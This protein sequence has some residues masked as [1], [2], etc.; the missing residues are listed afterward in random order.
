MIS[1]ALSPTERSTPGRTKHRTV[2]ERHALYDVLDT[3]LVCHIGLVLDDSPVVLP[4]GYGRDDDTLYLHGSTGARSLRTPPDG[5]D[6]CVTVTHVDGIVYARSLNHHSM[7][8]RSAVV[9]GRARPVTERDEKLHGL[10]V[11]TEHLA[12]GSWD[13][14]RGVSNKEYA[15]VSVLALP[16]HEASVKVRAEGPNDDPEDVEANAVWAGVLPVRQM[17]GTPEP[18]ADLATDL[19]VPTHV[20]A[21]AAA[22]VAGHAA[23]DTAD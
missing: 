10:K 14:A 6:I 3:G 17:F 23:T 4:T 1:T 21:R 15:A 5:V 8:Y 19:P 12:P 13:H 22:P 9:H 18:A 16:L 20:T 11:I 7:N 2:L